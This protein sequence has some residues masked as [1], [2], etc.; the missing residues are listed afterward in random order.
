MAYA[1]S[2]KLRTETFEVDSCIQGYHVFESTGE[3]LN[4][5]QERANTEDSYAVAVVHR[6]VVVGH[7]PQKMS[8]TCALFLRR[9]GIIRHDLH[10]STELELS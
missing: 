6:S 1:S 7:V 3:D 9:R 10:S 2:P 5:V 4:C 8:A